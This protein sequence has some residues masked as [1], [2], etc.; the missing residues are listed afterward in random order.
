MDEAQ[1][2]KVERDVCREL[3]GSYASHPDPV[4]QEKWAT[5]VMTHG[6]VAPDKE[7]RRERRPRWVWVPLVW[8]LLMA[9]LCGVQAWRY[10]N[11][12]AIDEREEERRVW[13]VT[14]V[15][16]GAN[17]LS[18]VSRTKQKNVTLADVESIALE[19]WTADRTGR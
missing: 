16:Y 4:C 5:T 3:G 19:R 15:R 9:G 13:F 6:P 14:G 1:L 10:A 8:F 11:G 12:L 2:A 18:E 7:L 17:A